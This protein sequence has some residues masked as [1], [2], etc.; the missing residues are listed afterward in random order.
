MLFVLDLQDMRFNP[1]Q[2]S[3]VLDSTALSAVPAPVSSSNLRFILHCLLLAF[4]ELLLYRGCFAALKIRDFL[5][6]DLDWTVGTHKSN[7]Y[8]GGLGV[9]PSYV[10]YYGR[11]GSCCEKSVRVRG[12]LSTAVKHSVGLLTERTVR[13]SITFV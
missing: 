4:P 13:R 12:N 6:I 3:V 11:F 1:C 7:L 8:F 5:G 9:R 2:S 10:N